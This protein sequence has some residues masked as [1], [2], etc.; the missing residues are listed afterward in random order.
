L[1]ER[2]FGPLMLMA[3][4]EAAA[5]AVTPKA[6][7]DILALIEWPFRTPYRVYKFF[8]GIAKR[9]RT[10]V[11][12]RYVDK[13]KLFIAEEPLPEEVLDQLHQAVEQNVNEAVEGGY[14]DA[15]PEKVREFIEGGLREELVRTLTGLSR[16]ELAEELKALEGV[17]DLQI[18]TVVDEAI[19]SRLETDIDRKNYEPYLD[20]CIA[21]RQ[22]E[23]RYEAAVKDVE[24]FQEAI[25]RAQQ[26]YEDHATEIQ[27]R[28][29]ELE[30]LR[31]DI[32]EKPT[33]PEDRAK[34]VKEL[35]EEIEK[36]V[37]KQK[38]VEERRTEAEGKK[39]EKEEERDKESE[40]KTKKDKQVEFHKKRWLKAHEKL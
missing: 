13:A 10:K 38:E 7:R 36:N 4:P 6:S 21:R 25:D 31:K 27:N 26:E 32:E 39:Q 34:R 37:E 5:A 28:K 2:F 14:R 12:D 3:L 35:E 18:K 24:K 11:L 20:S 8:Q 9:K 1:T 29:T 17:R 19:N 15:A 33:D 22:A 23:L 16:R 30:S 40:E